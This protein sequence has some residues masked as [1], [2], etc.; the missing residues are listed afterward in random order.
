[1]TEKKLFR[2]DIKQ[3]ILAIP[4]QEKEI[5]SK[6]IFDFLIQIPLYKKAEKIALYYSDKFEVDTCGLIEYSITQNKEVYLPKC[7]DDGRLQFYRVFSLDGLSLNCYNIPEPSVGKEYMGNFD[8]VTVPGLCF[9]LN[10]KRMGRGKGY[11]DKFLKNKKETKIAL[12]YHQL[13]SDDIPT[14]GGD[15]PVDIIISQKGVFYKNE[16]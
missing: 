11:Y 12:Y 8:V 9:G 2:A 1:M 13:L 16:V 6:K 14:D 10:G 7:G 3:K 15:V 4:E 5:I